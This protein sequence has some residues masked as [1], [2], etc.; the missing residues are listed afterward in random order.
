M[1]R[2]T[3]LWEQYAGKAQAE[4]AR[5]MGVWP[6]QLH[7]CALEPPWD[8]FDARTVNLWDCHINHWEGPWDGGSWLGRLFSA[9]TPVLPDGQGFVL[10]EIPCRDL[11]DLIPIVVEQFAADEATI[12]KAEEFLRSLTHVSRPLSFE[13]VGLGP[14]PIYDQQKFL[15]FTQTRPKGKRNYDEAITGW[16]PGSITTLFVAHKTDARQLERQ[17]VA[18]F[19]NSAIV[20]GDSST[21]WDNPGMRVRDAG[22]FGA[23]L[24]LD[25]FYCWPLRLFTRLDPDPL[26]VAIASMENLARDEW[27]V[28]QVLF[29]PAVRAWHDT[30]REAIQNPYEKEFLLP[31]LTD[32]MLKEK[33]ATPLFA[34]SIRIAAGKRDVFQQL[35]GWAEQFAALPQGLWSNFVEEEG[36]LCEIERDMLSTALSTRSTYRPG[37]LLN[38]QELS[39]LVHLP[40]RSVVSERLRQVKQRTRPVAETMAETGSVVL[41]NNIHR[42]QT[43][44]ARLPAK[45]R[46]RHCYIAGASGTGK[47]TLLLSMIMQDIQGG[48]GVGVLDPHGDLIKAILKRIP[49]E[50]IDDVILFDPAD[51]QFPFALNLLESKD[52]R[53]RERIVAE[54]V[55]ALER[56][57]PES[58][59][60][61]LELILTH[62]IY[63]VLEAIPGATLAD[64]E[65]MLLDEAFRSQVI[66]KIETPRFADFWSQQ[67]KFFPK[68]AVDPV[69][70]KLTPFLINRSVRNIICQRHAA[71]D[72]DQVLNGG[73]IL[74]ANL[75]T[76]LLTEKF[77]GMF[78]SFLVTKIV[79]AAFRRARLPEERRRPWYLYIDEFQAFMNLSVGFDRILT[80]ARKYKL[81]LAGLANQYVGQLSSPVRQA[82]FGNVGTYIVFRLGLED[83]HAV[84]REFRAF[85]ADE[86][87][88]LDVGQALVRAG[89]SAT[90]FNLQTFPEPSAKGEDFTRQIVNQNRKKFAKPVAEVEA[91]FSSKPKTQ[92]HEK[93]FTKAA[94]EPF[95][96]SEEDFVT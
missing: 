63:S 85:T 61:R 16:N 8:A 77:A 28:L 33:F 91:A 10:P 78:G 12:P 51:Q 68:N 88:D 94:P 95:D 35:E 79:N 39:G 84:A 17:L 14:E 67:F 73:K 19:P 92:P 60:P 5:G 71:I 6:P 23:T 59:G 45:L 86:I 81:V 34:V 52:E 90:A 96:P 27:A 37:L 80:E 89:T 62:T 15:H 43:R 48:Q 47:S 38:A 40:G 49:K 7:T 56:Y 50:R 13:I 87:L 9:D 72:F 4:A 93:R 36:Q 66:Q 30:L 65:R 20:P 11:D 83:A 76:G 57:F 41:G 18:H 1:R 69:L 2:P 82:I 42:G 74:L 55:M 64:V 70:N 22:T 21:L 29:E 32:R 46:A 26:G 53:E 75:S 54:T 31:D 24:A 3:R 44:V 58:W 25:H